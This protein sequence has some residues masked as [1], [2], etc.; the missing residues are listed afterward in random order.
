[1]LKGFRS[2][3]ILI[4]GQ[5]IIDP[6]SPRFT[7]IW[8][9]SNPREREWIEEIFG[10]WIAS[11]VTDSRHQMVLDNAILFDAFTY[12]VDPAYYAQFRG[13]NAF[14]VEFLDENYEGGR[15]E[16]YRNFRGVFRCHWSDAFVH[17]HVRKLPLGYGKGMARGGRPIQPA[18]RRRYVWSFIGHAGK[19]TRPDA[20]RALASIEPHFLFSTDDVPG[21]AIL[22]RVGGQPK[23]LPPEEYSQILL[24]SAFSPC[25]MGNVNIECFRMYESL[26]CGA[27]PIVEKRATLDYY[28]KLLGDHPI[29]TVRSWSEAARMIRRMLRNPDDIDVLQQQCIAWWGDYKRDYRGQVGRFLHERSARPSA[30]P[31]PVMTSMQKIPGWRTIELLRHHNSSAFLR[32]VNRQLVRLVRNRKLRVAYRPGVPLD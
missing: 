2:L 29:P 21:L 31:I 9:S 27:I 1:M 26:E 24:E 14:L 15:Y 16:L 12:C 11:H 13:K 5:D 7:A 4:N 8:Q 28:R 22:N 17:D 18:A 6:V 19:S 25:P 3:R 20:V 10:P 30:D 32:R 23:R